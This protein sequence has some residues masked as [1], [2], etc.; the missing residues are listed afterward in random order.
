MF[1]RP[2][3]SIYDSLPLHQILPNLD[4]INIPSFDS[5]EG[6]NDRFA[7]MNY[8][9][10]IIYGKRIN[11]IAEFR[12]NNGRIVSEKYLK[13]IIHKYNLNVNLINFNFVFVRPWNGSKIYL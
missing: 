4:K 13:F 11:E 7:I 3:V 10:A 6:Y 1:I 12:K 2:D 8:K 9:N 5:N